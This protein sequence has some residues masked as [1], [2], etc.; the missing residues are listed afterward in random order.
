MIKG[1]GGKKKYEKGQGFIEWI[2]F[3]ILN[4]SYI[5]LQQIAWLL[6]TGS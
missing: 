2:I 3:L 4:I 6:R 5:F 1:C